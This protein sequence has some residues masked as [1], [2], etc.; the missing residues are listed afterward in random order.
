VYALG[1]LLGGLVVQLAGLSLANPL[2]AL[3]ADPQADLLG[4]ARDT[5][6]ILGLQ[7]AGILL[8]AL[9]LGWWHRRRP[10][11]AYG[12]R[13]AGQPLPRLLLAGLVLFAVSGLPILLLELLG[14]VVPLGPRTEFQEAIYARAWDLP[15]WVFLAVGSFGL[16]PIV[17]ELFYRGYVQTRLA[18][19]FGAPAAI[20]VTAAFF[21]FSHGQY[22]LEPSPRN[23]LQ[24]VSLLFAALAW[25]YLFYR[26]GSL[27][28]PILA[29]VLVN[30]PMGT[31]A[32]VGLVAVLLGVVVLARDLIIGALRTGWMLFGSA[33]LPR[34]ATALGGL[35]LV[36]FAVLL[37][38]MQD[39]ALLLGLALL[40]VALV[41]E[42]LEKR[43]Q[44]LTGWTRWPMTRSA[45]AD[46]DGATRPV[47][48]GLLFD[49]A[50]VAL[51]CWVMIGLF[52]DGWAH[53]HQ[54]RLESFL[55]PWHAVLYSG[56][57]AQLALLGAALGRGRAQG[58]SWR[59]AAPSGYG[60]S[61][62]GAAVFLLAGLADFGWHAA[63]GI[64]A[65]LEALLSPPHLALAAGLGLMLSGPLRAAW[66]C[67][68]SL[69]G[70]GGHLPMLLSL[71]LLLALLGFFTGYGHPFTGTGLVAGPAPREPE[72]V[73]SYQARGILGI[74]LQSGLLMG[75]LLPIVRRHGATLPPG[76][77]T[78]VLGLSGLLLSALGGRY[79]PVVAAL[80]A[81][82][83]ADLWLR[84]LRPT[85]TRPWAMHVFA[86]VVPATLYG[87]Y[88]AALELWVGHVW[89]PVHLWA[90][91]V[92]LAG[93]VGLLLST[94]ALPSRGSGRLVVSDGQ[95]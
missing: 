65:N 33:A 88:F 73:Y 43:R 63:F 39:V 27:L 12:L 45:P 55:T 13:T 51:S 28:V 79:A 50:S 62:V 93:V 81:G 10:L 84:W 52:L 82:A 3:A 38:A 19:D 23:A 66:Q 60:L 9:A 92:V 15:F 72:L 18:E 91:A 1:L 42:V 64:E 87:A 24:L 89:W 54:P 36:L 47:V 80:L 32:A 4:L 14:R 61:L 71:G 22:Y 11:R 67:T 68:R 40:A 31:P 70:W 75:A 86:F 41:A 20:V 90:G 6:A 59:R 7:Y 44:T 48:R 53:E 34:R 58:R 30:V 35:A 16:V 37:A 5:A 46:E 78:L 69:S 74:L 85:T 26:S 8:P 21:T 17:E 29:H 77:V 95:P 94:V 57:L 83:V 2:Q 56:A 49:G 25:G 76:A